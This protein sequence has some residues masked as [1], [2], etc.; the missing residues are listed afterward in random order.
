VSKSVDSVVT[1]RVFSGVCKSQPWT[2]F[3]RMDH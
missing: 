3:G 2:Y 1:T